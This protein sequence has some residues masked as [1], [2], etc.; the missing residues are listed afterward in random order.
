L[1]SNP[2]K[3]KGKKSR[4][5]GGAGGKRGEEQR[6]IQENMEGKNG[7]RVSLYTCGKRGKEKESSSTKKK[8]SGEPE[9]ANDGIEEVRY[10]FP[11]A[12]RKKTKTHEGN[13]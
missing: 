5:G 3:E 10:S 2:R 9:P 6:R 11:V 12:K 7:D 4:N 1:S 13:K 8:I